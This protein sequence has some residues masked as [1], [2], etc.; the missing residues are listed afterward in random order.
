[1]RLSMEEVRLYKDILQGKSGN[2]EFDALELMRILDTIEAQHQDIEQ[3]KSMTKGCDE[4]F[5]FKQRGDKVMVLSKLKAQVAAL[6][7]ALAKAYNALKH[8]QI[9]NAH[10]FEADIGTKDEIQEAITDIDKIL[11]GEYNAV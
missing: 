5:F 9:N 8:V 4:C 1:V 3:L 10:G 7:E 6:R 11:G 2:I